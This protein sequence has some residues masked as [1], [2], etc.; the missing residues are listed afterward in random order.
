MLVEIVHKNFQHY[1]E[2][3]TFP[4]LDINECLNN[5]CHSNGMCTNIP[6]SFQCSCQVG[7]TGDGFFCGGRFIGLGE[8]KIL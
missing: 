5:P 1:K 8:N 7:F 2:S 4:L 3:Y 6:G